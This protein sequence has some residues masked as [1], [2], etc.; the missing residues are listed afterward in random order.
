MSNNAP[1]VAT[2]DPT[3]T[4]APAL[5]TGKTEGVDIQGAIKAFRDE[6]ARER[7]GGW[8][9]VRTRERGRRNQLA[10]VELHAYLGLQRG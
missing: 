3:P 6:K 8:V 2:G 4:K 1:T 7:E 5:E 10:V 9:E